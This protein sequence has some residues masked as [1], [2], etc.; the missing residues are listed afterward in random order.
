MKTLVLLLLTVVSLSAATVTVQTTVLPLV[1][2]GQLVQTSAE[3]LT[4]GDGAVLVQGENVAA[5]VQVAS[6]DYLAV[7]AGRV[8][9]LTPRSVWMEI[10]AK[11]L[12]VGVMAE[13]T[14]LMVRMLRARRIEG[15]DV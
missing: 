5:W 9:V 7:T 11:G 13:L 6:G 3:T 15:G 12:F 1:V 8:E 2:D 10:F 14:G 4:V